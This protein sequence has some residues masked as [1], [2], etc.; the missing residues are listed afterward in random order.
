MNQIIYLKTMKK[1]LI[2]KLKN[3]CIFFFDRKFKKPKLIAVD[4]AASLG[5]LRS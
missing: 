5:R 3:N 2:D 4:I 1:L